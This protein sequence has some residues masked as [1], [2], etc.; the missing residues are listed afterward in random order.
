MVWIECTKIYL[1]KKKSTHKST[2]NIIVI[3]LMI[4]IN[5]YTLKKYFVNLYEET[6]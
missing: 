3:F 5:L 1:N 2:P 6:P 4:D